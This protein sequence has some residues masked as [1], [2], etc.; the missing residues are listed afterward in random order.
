M[1]TH[2][3]PKRPQSR[4]ALRCTAHSEYAAN[5]R[6]QIRLVLFSSPAVCCFFLLVQLLCSVR[7]GAGSGA[8]HS[9]DMPL[10]GCTSVGFPM[11]FIV[12][13]RQI[14]MILSANMCPGMSLR[15][16]LMSVSR[17]SRTSAAAA[18]SSSKRLHWDSSYG[19]LGSFSEGHMRSR[20]FRVVLA[21]FFPN[22]NVVHMEF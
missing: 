15:P 5:T 21:S 16:D 6:I 11:N 2:N 17:R 12:F 10:F 19:L 7:E 1:R 14:N 13:T 3:K 9:L 8:R 20:S 22:M 18:K 4:G